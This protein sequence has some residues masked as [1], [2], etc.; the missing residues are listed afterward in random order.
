MDKK[1]IVS[2]IMAAVML[3]L[4]AVYFNNSENDGLIIT[5]ESVENSNCELQNSDTAKNVPETSSALSDTAKTVSDTEAQ[6]LP[7]DDTSPITVMC[8]NSKV[9]MDAEEYIISVVAGEVSPTYGPEA[10]KAQAVAARTYLYYKISG[11]GCNKGADICTDYRH[12]QAY[13]SKENMISQWGEKFDKYYS[14]IKDAV[15]ST[16]GEIIVYNNKPIC[17]LY[18]SSSVG[19][20]ENCVSVFGGNYPY[21]VSVD[22]EIDQSD[23]E[24]SKTVTFSEKEFVDKINTAFPEANISGID[25]KIVAYTDAGRVAALKIGN[26]TVKATALRS[27]LSLRST[28]FTFDDSNGK[29]AFTTFGFGHGVGMSQHGAQA[30]AQEG[31]TYKEILLHYYPGTVIQKK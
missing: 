11:G 23:S 28:D 26:A 16:Q 8:E 18:H 6:N 21:L 19:K 1:I 27:A 3:F 17:A 20:T 12:C 5:V 7:A 2:V 15:Y 31:K 14:A 24:Y 13:K 10:L 4:G 25:I 9:Q 22:T 30:M 29:I